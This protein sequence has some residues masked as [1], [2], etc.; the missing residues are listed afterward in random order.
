VKKSAFRG[1]PSSPVSTSPKGL[2]ILKR[3]LNELQALYVEATNILQDLLIGPS[4]ES[5]RDL[6][7]RFRI[8]Q[9]Y[10]VMRYREAREL[11]LSVFGSVEAAL[12]FFRF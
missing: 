9:E 12:S 5:I 4:A 2:R 3:C 10:F 1:Q 11:A 7:A 6:C 8:L